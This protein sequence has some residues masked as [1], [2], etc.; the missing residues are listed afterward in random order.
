MIRLD[1]TIRVPAQ[2]DRAFAYLAKWEHIAEWDPGV[3]SADKQFDGP[4]KVGGTYALDYSFNGRSMP[5]TYTIADLHHPHRLVLTGEAKQLSAVDTITLKSDGDGT[6]IRYVADLTFRGVTRLFEG[7]LK[8]RLK[9][10]GREAVEGLATA[11][12]AEPA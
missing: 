9:R 3:T 10:I 2:I 1:E 7:F 5:M 6:E 8:S 11:L 12:G 4:P